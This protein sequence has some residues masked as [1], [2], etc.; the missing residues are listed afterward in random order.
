MGA[1]APAVAHDG[2]GETDPFSALVFSKTAGFRH[3]SIPAGIAAIEQLGAEHG[4]TVDATEDA[5]VFTDDTLD[6]YDVVIWLSTTGDVL[7]ADQQAAFERYVADGGGYAGVHAASDTEYDWPWYGELVGAYFAN[8]PAGTPDVTVK[9]Q[10]PAHPS[11]ADLPAL[12]TRTDE[13]YNFRDNP[14]Q[15]VHV[16][17]SLDETSYEGGTMGPEHPISWCQDY[18]GGRAWYT[19]LGHTDASFSE[20]EFLDHLLGG[21]RTAAGVQAADCGATL[22]ESFEKV[23]LD[24]NTANPMELDIADD[25]RVFYID[26]NGDVRVIQPNGNV[27]TAGTLEVYTGQEFGLLGIALDPDFA[28]NDWV[29]LY[30]S[31]AGSE[32]VDRVTRFT[33]DGNTLDRASATEIL[34]IPVQRNECC[35]AGGALEFD[36]DGNLYVATG[37][38]TNP[39]ASD[40]YAPLDERDGRAA[41]DSQRTSANTN[42]LS[43]KILRIT[44]KDE[45]GY[46][47]P[48]GNLYAPGTEKTRPEIYGMGFRNPFRI[49]L[50]EQTGAILVA[51]Y[52]PDAGSANPDRGPDGRVEWNIV[53]EPGFY[54]WPYCVGDVTPYIDYDF[55]TGQSGDAFDCSAPVNDSPNNTGLTELPPVQGAELW[56]GKSSTDNSEIGG[57]GAPM[58]SGTYAYDPDLESDRKWPAY[59]DEK[60]IWADWNNSRLFTVQLNDE[61][62]DVVDLN[63]FLPDLPMTRPHALQFGPDGAL[64]MIEWGSGFGGN[65]ADSGV[66]RI[67]YV[68][69]NRAP[70]AK[71][72]ATPTSGAAPLT[73]EFDATGSRDPDGTAVTYAWDFDGDGTTDSTDVTTSHTYTE[74][75]DYT[76][77]LTV[78]DADGRTAVSNLDIVVG[79]TAPTVE[80]VAP[81]DGGFFEFG[82]TIAYEVKVTDPEDGEIDCDKVV[83]QPALGHD[84]HAHGYEQY[85]GCSGTLPLPGDEGHVGANIF[86]TITA[87]YTDDGADGASALTGQDTVVLHTKRTEAE[88]FDAT[89]RVGDGT[90]GDP[91]VIIEDASDDLGGGSNIGYIEPGD[92]IRWDVMNLTNIDEITF[93]AASDAGGAD[94]EVRTGAPDGPV[95]ATIRVDATAGWQE[96]E[97]FS[98]E[99]S[100]ETATRSGPLYFVQTSGGSNINWIDFGGRGVTENQR[101]ELSLTAD[102][103]DGQV[104]LEVAFTAEATDPDGDDP[105]TFTWNFGDGATDDTGESGAATHTYTESGTYRATVTATDARGA[106]ATRTVTIRVGEPLPDCFTGRSDGFDG[107]ALDTD[108]WDSNVRVDEDLSVQDGDLVIDLAT[109]DLYGSPGGRTPNL[110]LQHLPGGAFEATTKMSLPAT[111]QYQQAGL[112]VYGDDDNYMKLVLQGRSATPNRAAN[113]VQFLTEVGGSPT[114]TNSAA[115]GA[116]F[117]DSIWLRLSSTNGL[118]VTAQYSRDGSTWQT[119]NGTRSLNG[120]NEP[121]IGLWGT[122]NQ[123]A[124]L[125][126]AARFDYFTFTPDDTA[127]D[128]GDGTEDTTAPTVEVSTDPSEP[129]GENGWYTSAVTVTATATDDVTDEPTLEYRVGDGEWTAYEG[130]VEV[131]EDGTH[132]VAFRATDEAGN[133]SQVESVEVKV[134][135]TDPETTVSGVEDGATVSIA[136]TVEVAVEA[137]D[138]TSGVASV[139]MTL[140]GEAVDGTE[141][142]LE[143]TALGSG[144]HV[145]EV[146]ATDEAGNTATETVTFTVE[147]TFEAAQTVLDRLVD[148]GDLSAKQAKTLARHLALAEKHADAGR[149][150][151]AERELD[152]FVGAARQVTDAETRAILLDLGEALRAGL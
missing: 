97:Y 67:D 12:W 122:A 115:L 92:W 144:E 10:D 2:H 146:T 120:I 77:R 83:V 139:S 118:D 93:R 128:C 101:P 69:G 140:D 36:N 68:Q 121:R 105:I 79:N 43:G 6:D 18:E 89:G 98:G 1:S 151:N 78:T 17:A 111:R 16:L 8:H 4:F 38:N 25:G 5:G 103:T 114:E 137:T 125:P 87:T 64:Y 107:T 50:D 123:E 85:T 65:N 61:H 109:P 99:V 42:S 45:G 49:G 58:T 39:F 9:V 46:D 59:F 19:G 88:F 81:V 20:P 41:W 7:N 82:D 13:L 27:S 51:D 74:V 94:W 28:T 29:Y 130:P 40:G 23:T 60:A 136:D 152:R 147:V 55:A 141:A 143:G 133:V 3:G 96:Y 119:V 108:R 75:G 31:P 150:A 104:P 91:G 52:G 106:K 54:G 14:M 66:Y 129:N 56:Q 135:A 145:I 132:T 127:T 131:T 126:I 53:D 35:H 44:P 11:T 73:V 15:D 26:R 116:D 102:V 72:S 149:T 62:T 80:I 142:S 113:V 138:A 48:D 110:V 148:E 134:D 24:D 117:P 22:G 86:G 37:D 32:S 90:N 76:A 33:M 112:I 34:E 84:E 70:I 71:A 47:I 21:I 57:S 63:R 95:V 30:H 100:G 124:A